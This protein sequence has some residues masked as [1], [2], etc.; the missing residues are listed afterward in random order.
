MH[1][2]NQVDTRFLARFVFRAKMPLPGWEAAPVG[3]DT[4]GAEESKKTQ[5]S[6]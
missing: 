6:S 2:Q 4:H 1:P 5:T 3:A